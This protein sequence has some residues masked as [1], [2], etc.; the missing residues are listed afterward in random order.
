[1]QPS[2]V[3]DAH[4]PVISSDPSR[5]PLAPLSGALPDWM[6]NRSV[7]AEQLLERMPGAGVDKAVLVQYSSAHG[8]D[9]SYVLDTAT[10]HPDR[11]VAICTVDGRAPDA[12]AQL[13]A[14]VHRGAAGL[15]IRAPS[16]DGPLDWL[17]CEPLWQRAAELSIPVCVHF[18]ESR[19]ADGVRRLPALLERFPTVTVVLDHVANPP[20]REGP[21]AYGLSPV[22]ELASFER[23]YIKFATINLE[24][25]H[26]AVIAPRLAI[27]RLVA[28]YSARRIMWGSD[29]PN[30]PGN[31]AEMVQRML[32]A[33]SDVTDDERRWIMGGTALEVYPRLAAHGVVTHAGMSIA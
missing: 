25:L 13:A 5:Y 18:S 30:T 2:S 29:A 20:W 3:V 14:C 17:D 12:A 23:L 16:R 26:Q 22:L 21:P 9:N 24:R 28:A 15:R 27:E 1:M 31:Y 33:L 7:A 11:F 4:A 6:S 10:A 19:Q 8:Y 32:S